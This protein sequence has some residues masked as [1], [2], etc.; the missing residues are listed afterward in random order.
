MGAKMLLEKL[1]ER[2]IEAHCWFT[3]GKGFRVVWWD[4]QGYYEYTKRDYGVS[5]RVLDSLL[6]EIVGK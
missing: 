4:R 2:G 1:Q 6:P 3:G 5:N